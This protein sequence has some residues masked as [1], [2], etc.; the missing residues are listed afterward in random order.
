MGARRGSCGGPRVASYRE[1]GRREKER[2][3]EL[4]KSDIPRKENF[5][6]CGGV[7]NDWTKCF[8]PRIGFGPLRHWRKS[9]YW[10]LVMYSVNLCS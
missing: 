4:K 7:C 10:A 3:Q 5:I 8:L 6:L 2:S 9:E 1:Q